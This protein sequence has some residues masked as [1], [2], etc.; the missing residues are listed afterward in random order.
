[1]ILKLNDPEVQQSRS[2]MIPIPKHND[3]KAQWSQSETISKHNVPEAQGSRSA[4]IKKC[5]DSDPK[6]QQSRSQSASIQKKLSQR[7]AMNEICHMSTK[8]HVENIQ[9][10][11]IPMCKV[12]QFQSA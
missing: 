9:I 7:S 5:N 10:A 3:P 8:I 1:M 6:K 11:T 4:T 2:A 12:Q